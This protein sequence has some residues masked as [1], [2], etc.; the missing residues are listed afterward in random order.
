VRRWFNALFLASALVTAGCYY[1]QY[2]SGVGDTL[3]L[4]PT[5]AVK[6][7]SSRV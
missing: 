7:E 2:K 5:H 1:L 3:E 6:K 4:L